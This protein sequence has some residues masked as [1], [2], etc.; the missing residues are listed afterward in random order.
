MNLVLITVLLSSMFK[1]FIISVQSPES[2][3]EVPQLR[4][5]QFPSQ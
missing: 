3:Q 5:G 2:E 1:Y 4:D